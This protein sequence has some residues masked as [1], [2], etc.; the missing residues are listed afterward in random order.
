MILKTLQLSNNLKAHY[1]E[2]GEGEP[3]VLIHGVGMQA[4]AWYPQINYFSKHYH[5]ISVD[6]PGHGKSDRLAE[7]ATLKD[8][9]D[10]TIEFIEALN[11]GPV[12]LAGHSMGSLISAGVSI[13]RPDLV[14]RVAVLNGVYKR[15]PEASQAVIHR[16]LELQNGHID[17]Q[18]PLIR[19]F[20]DSEHEKVAAEKVKSWLENVDIRGYATAY[21]AFAHGDAI[22]A[23]LWN[24]ILCPALVLTGTGDANST[25]EMTRAMASQAPQGKAVVIDNERHMVNLTAPDLVNTAMQN[26]LNTQV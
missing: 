16:A 17:I 11:L 9:V 6:M 5:V 15:T 20:G 24:E 25:A 10:W 14:K 21:S 18:T 4:M 2:Q 13:T 26:W 12:N 3:L 1:L 22:Y 7:C 23:D 19:W 8:F